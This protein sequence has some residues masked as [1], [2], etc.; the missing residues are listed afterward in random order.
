MLPFRTTAKQARLPLSQHLSQ[1][2]YVNVTRVSTLIRSVQ[3]LQSTTSLLSSTQ[4]FQQP[5]SA[6]VNQLRIF[7]SMLTCCSQPAQ[8]G[9]PGL[10]GSTRLHGCLP[11]CT[12]VH[13][14]APVST[15]LQGC[16]S[17]CKGVQQPAKQD[18]WLY[19]V[20][21]TTALLNLP[22][23]QARTEQMCSL[24]LNTHEEDAAVILKGSKA[25]AKVKLPCCQLSR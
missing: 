1:H 18:V 20:S 8:L 16:P 23:P 13:Q 10:H 12:S 3:L 19:M 4:L 24:R 9:H 21:L 2:V 25:P 5:P 17:T 14:P 22:R 15:Y 7:S 6:F 11:A